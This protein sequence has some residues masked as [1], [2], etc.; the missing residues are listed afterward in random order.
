MEIQGKAGKLYISDV[1]AKNPKGSVVL[2][3]GICH[4]A[5]CWDK[6]QDYLALHGFD[7]YALSYRGHKGSDG[8]D[9][10]KDWT[11]SDYTD[12]VRSTIEHVPQITG[13][14][15]F[16]LG[17][18]MGGAVVQK[19]IGTDENMVR[20]AILFASATA[21]KMP[22]LTTFIGSY[23]RKDLSIA[24]R[25]SEGKSVDIGEMPES[26]FFK[27]GEVTKAAIEK[28]SPML[29]EESPE[30]VKELVLK[31]YSKNYNINIPVF[32]IGSASDSY[33]KEDSLNKTADMYK[34]EPVIL[35]GICHDM[36]LDERMPEVADHVIH[37]MEKVGL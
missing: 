9:K 23:M 30:V 1:H 7:S 34:V 5:W 35:K 26:A 22:F 16:L 37:F 32:V 2:A 18:S 28:Y 17:H 13:E 27:G 10:L 25:I 29:Q 15:P 14:K 11:I 20:G 21:P 24:R 31:K 8:F 3:H 6:M 19:Y 4:G 33:F 12:D 36:M